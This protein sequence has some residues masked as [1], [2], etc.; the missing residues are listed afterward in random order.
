M[1]VRELECVGQQHYEREAFKSMGHDV[2][3]AVKVYHSVIARRSWSDY[4]R[5]TKDLKS[6]PGVVPV[7]PCHP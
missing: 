1:S 6:L 3:L 4:D 7:D 5:G 2:I